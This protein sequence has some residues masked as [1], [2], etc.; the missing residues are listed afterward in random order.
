MYVIYYKKGFFMLKVVYGIVLGVVLLLT[1]VIGINF[2]LYTVDVKKLKAQVNELEIQ[3]T[4]QQESIEKIAKVKDVDIV[5]PKKPPT[6][7][8]KVTE[9][10]KKKHTTT[11]RKPVSPPMTDAWGWCRGQKFKC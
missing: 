10:P 4:M 7:K 6:D 1:V 3:S 8:K 9:P 11:K 2:W 5:V